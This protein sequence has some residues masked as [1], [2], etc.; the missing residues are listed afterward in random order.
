MA[1]HIDDDTWSTLRNNSV[2]PRKKTVFK[3]ALA[4]HLS[5]DEAA[6][7]LAKANKRFDDNN[8]Q[9]LI[10]MALLGIKDYTMDDVLETFDFYQE[11]LNEF[12]PNIYDTAKENKKKREKHEQRKEEER[13]K[14]REKYKKQKND[15]NS[16]NN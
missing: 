4:L 16:G 2:I 1:S 11:N 5:Q 3:I 8:N 15:A 13:Q 10:V 6:E 9:D 14:K 7:L 12:L